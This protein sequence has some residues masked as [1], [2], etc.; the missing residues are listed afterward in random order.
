MKKEKDARINTKHPV[1]VEYFLVWFIMCCITGGQAMVFYSFVPIPEHI[2]I[3]FI[4]ANIGYWGL[5]AFVFVLI[6]MIMRKKTWEKPVRKLGE[7]ARM[8][9]HGDFSVHID[10][11]RKDGKKDYVEVMFDDFN[12]MVEELSGIEM[13][14]G[15]F[16]SNVSHEIKTPLAVIQSYAAALQKENISPQERKEYSETIITAS[17]KLNTLVT[18]V[19]KLSKLE[20]QKIVPNLQDYDLCGQLAECALGFEDLLENKNITFMA[21]MDDRAIISADKNMLEI[22]WNNLLSNAIKFTPQGGAITFTQTSDEDTVCVSISDSGLGMDENTI[23]RIFDKFYQGDTSHSQDGNG[24][25]LALVLRVVELCGGE[26]LVR[27]TTGEGSVFTVK[28]K[29]AS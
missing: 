16:V 21:D 17:E 26:I 10:P 11:I 6:T 27:S 15:D 19:L 2:P 3:E 7:A 20:N 9:T 13:L 25:G 12:K 8:V 23:H 4:F 28:L 1:W 24:L 5:M 18:N 22:V 29:T 14:T